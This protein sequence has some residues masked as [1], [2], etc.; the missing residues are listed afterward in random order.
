MRFCA[1]FLRDLKDGLQRS[2]HARLAVQ[3][4]S[5]PV[6]EVS[7]STKPISQLVYT[8]PKASLPEGALPRVLLDVPG[9]F[10]LFVLKGEIA[11]VESMS[12]DILAE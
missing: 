9:L 2:R 10:C 6:H 8:V 12:R 1:A 7:A 4:D 5:L 11:A 3:V